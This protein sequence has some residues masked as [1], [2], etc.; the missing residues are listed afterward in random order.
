MQNGD[1]ST[2]LSE[3]IQ[4][5]KERRMQKSIEPGTWLGKEDGTSL[6]GWSKTGRGHVEDLKILVTYTPTPRDFISMAHRLG[7]CLQCC[8]CES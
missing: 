1:I 5:R 3:R 7:L 4:A 6:K 8:L 2:N